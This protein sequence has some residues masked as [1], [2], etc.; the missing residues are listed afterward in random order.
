MGIEFDAASTYG[1]LFDSGRTVGFS[2]GTGPFRHLQVNIHMHD[3]VGVSGIPTYG[4]IDLIFVGMDINF[5]VN[6]ART[7][8]Y[9]LVDPPSG[10]NNLIYVLSGN[11]VNGAACI[12]RTGVDPN[13]P[14]G[15]M[16]SANG[17]TST[18]ATVDVASGEGEL[19]IDSCSACQGNPGSLMVGALQTPR[20][21]HNTTAS[22]GFSFAGSEESGK[23]LVTMSHLQTSSTPLAWAIVAVPLKPKVA[24]FERAVKY[25]HNVL[26]PTRAIL[27]NAG[28]E[29]PVDQIKGDDYLRTLGI[30]LPT[31][32]V[33]SDLIRNPEVGYIESVKVSE[34]EG[35]ARIKAGKES[36]LETFLSRIAGR[37]V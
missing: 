8:M 1:L 33:Y 34:T 14:L 24:G 23:P 15:T 16:V 35:S 4:G 7:Y 26:D 36:L 3:N 12:S 27:D 13:N 31:A 37:G 20:S 32:K 5:N 6:G 30:L 18:P 21:L 28:R 9:E 17:A 29:I 25:F 2:I 11:G 10:A 22:F 19:V